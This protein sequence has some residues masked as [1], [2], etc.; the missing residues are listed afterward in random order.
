MNATPGT[1]RDYCNIGAGLAGYIIELQ[2]GQTLNEYAKK[3]IFHPL[4]MQNSGWALNEI[5][6]TNHSKLYEKRRQ[7]CANSI[8]RN[9][10]IPRWWY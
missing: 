9:D 10:N 1:N 6:I 8:V 3:N 2:T 5:N 4:K 7:Y